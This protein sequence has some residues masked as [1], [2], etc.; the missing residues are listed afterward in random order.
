MGAVAAVGGLD[1][2]L[3]ETQLRALESKEFVRRDRRSSMVGEAQY[4]F[5]HVLVRDVAYGQIPRTNRAERHQ[6]A[7]RWLESPDTADRPEIR[8]EMLAHHYLSALE[9]AR[10]AGVDRGLLEAQAR[11]ALVEAGDR[12]HALHAHAAAEHLYSVAL[13]LAAPDDEGRPELLFKYGRSRFDG[14]EQGAEE[15][16]EAAALL[17]AQGNREL[18]AEAEM[19]F[20]ALLVARATAR[21]RSAAWSER[22]SFSPR[23]G[24][25]GEGVRSRHVRP[26]PHAGRQD[27]EAVRLG[28]AALAM[29]TARLRR[30]QRAGAERHRRLAVVLGDE[31]GIEDLQRAISIARRSTADLP[32]ALAF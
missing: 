10:P 20:C 6:R 30:R 22:T 27:D 2:S 4:A 14:A 12:A 3:V 24:L 16:T 25:G 17:L 8:A 28:R 21:G 29:T 23:R 32:A 26:L 18:A 19:I 5:L 7:A 11:S 31:A 13:D 9:Y 15:L 1:P